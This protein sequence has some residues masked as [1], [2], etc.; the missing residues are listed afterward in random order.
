M[1]TELEPLLDQA[2]DDETDQGL[3]RLGE[4]LMQS[5]YRCT[6][7][8]PLTH[9]YN[10]QRAANRL[11]SDLRDILGWSRPFERSVVTDREFDLM[12]NADILTPQGQQWRSMVRWSSLGDLL[13]AH[14]AYPTDTADAVF[15]GP[16]TYRFAQ[17]IEPFFM[18]AGHSVERAID[19]G[20]GSGAGALLIAKAC[21]QTQVLAV[22]INPQ[23]LRLTRINA[24]LASADNVEPVCSNLLNDVKG[25]FDLIVANPP[26]MLDARQRAYRHGGGELGAGLSVN[27]VEAALQRL[28]PGG[29][30]L[31]YTGVAIVNGSD[32]FLQILEQQLSDQPYTW[33]YREIDPDVFSEELLKPTYAKVERI[34][35]VALTIQRS[36]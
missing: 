33:H 24:R 5:G 7:V 29:T 11:A 12:R 31:L 26:Y 30:L 19:I 28:T 25:K 35:A 20:C 2:D 4:Y 8:T 32:A 10:N 9:Q 16:D 1:E 13:C 18:T 14:S 36:Q 21:P 17:L 22:D 15:F 3:L 6:A 27:I 23:A 34:A